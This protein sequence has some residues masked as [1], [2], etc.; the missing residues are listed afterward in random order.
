MISPTAYYAVEHNPV[1]PTR[2]FNR[3]LEAAAKL[4]DK[5][6]SAR[7]ALHERAPAPPDP[8][9]SAV[10]TDTPQQRL[11]LR[12]NRIARKVRSQYPQGQRVTTGHMSGTVQRHVPQLTSQGGYLVV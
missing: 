7:L 5:R 12:R 10:M 6:P 4:A 11:A 1:R 3:A 2:N 8:P 9:G